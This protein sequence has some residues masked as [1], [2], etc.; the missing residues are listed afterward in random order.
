[1]F[2]PGAWPAAIRSHART[3]KR[4]NVAGADAPRGAE[5]DFAHSVTIFLSD[6]DR[7]VGPESVRSG[8]VMFM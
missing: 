6:I 4:T 5:T 7:F 2:G 3:A 1:M 8:R